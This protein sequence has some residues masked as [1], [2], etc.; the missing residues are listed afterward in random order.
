MPLTPPVQK[1]SAPV[2]TGQPGVHQFTTPAALVPPVSPDQNEKIQR[3][4]LAE[5]DQTWVNALEARLP[6]W[7]GP[8]Q[9]LVGNANTAGIPGSGWLGEGA[10]DAE[11]HLGGPSSY[12][13]RIRGVLHAISEY[14]D[15][16]YVSIHRFSH[17]S[18]C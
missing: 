11:R 12:P 1:T 8:Q 9:I 5:A 15:T 4:R 16:R 14:R 13:Q 17:R 2:E 18:I 3:E 6:K 10:P 7:Q